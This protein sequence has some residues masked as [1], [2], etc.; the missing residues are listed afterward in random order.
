MKD[1]KSPRGC[2]R[3]AENGKG[4][5]ERCFDEQDYFYLALEVPSGEKMI[6]EI[7]G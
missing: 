7:T 3:D 6:G 1:G 5:A 2:K 4:V